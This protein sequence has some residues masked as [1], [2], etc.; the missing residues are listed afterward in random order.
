MAPSD[1][2]YT[3]LHWSAIVR[4]ADIAVTQW[5]KMGFSL[6]PSPPAGATH[7]P[8]KRD[9][10]AIRSPVP[11]ITFIGAEMRQYSPKTV[12]IWNFDHKFVH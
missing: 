10:T 8:D 6:P 3:T 7:C 12:K 11:N 4:V 9:L 2:P 5:F 1:K